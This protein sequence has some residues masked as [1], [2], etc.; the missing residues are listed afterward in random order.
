[1]RSFAV[2]L[3]VVAAMAAGCGG[4]DD[5]EAGSPET[6]FAADADAICAEQARAELAAFAD[7]VAPG[8]VAPGYL[9]GVE[10]ARR[11]AAEDLAAL[12]PPEAESAS[13]EALVAEVE[14]SA[15]LVADAVAAADAGDTAELDRLRLR[16]REVRDAINAAAAEAGLTDC[17]GALP[18]EDLAAIESTLALSVDGDAAE[19]LCRERITEAFLTF[20][21]DGELD[22]C[23]REQSGGP[24]SEVDIE[25][26]F[27]VAGL[28]A[29]GIAVLGDGHRY[30][31][32]LAFEDD[33]W[34]LNSLSAAPEA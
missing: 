26:I 2:C 8:E 15:S 11:A 3:I 20:R 31:V 18:D 12:T 9:E 1:M 10:S 28:Y 7:N 34:K 6:S 27:G 25:E 21:F 17:A 5:E 4:G 23:I 14:S 30:E 33:V 19:E 29:N 16:S 32:S 24:S 22:S 13:V